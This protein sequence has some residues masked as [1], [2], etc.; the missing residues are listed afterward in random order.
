MLRHG[1]TVNVED[2]FER[3]T[4]TFRRLSQSCL[5]KTLD[6]CEVALPF[7]ERCDAESC[8]DL[9]E[10]NPE[11]IRVPGSLLRTIHDMKPY[12]FVERIDWTR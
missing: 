4:I 2:F 3:T 9:I 12:R 11:K 10:L 6:R 8:Y 7:F 5:E 1:V